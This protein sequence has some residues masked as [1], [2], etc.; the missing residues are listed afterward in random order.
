MEGDVYKRVADCS[1]RLDDE[2][3][4]IVRNCSICIEGEPTEE[5]EVSGYRTC[6]IE[7]IVRGGIALV[8][9][10]GIALKGLSSEDVLASRAGSGSIPGQ[11]QKE[12]GDL[13]PSSCRPHCRTAVFPLP[14]GRLRL[15][16]GRP[17]IQAWL[18]ESNP[19][20]LLWASL[21]QPEPRSQSSRAR[22]QPARQLHRGADGAAAERGC[23]RLDS[24]DIWNGCR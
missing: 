22:R 2:I 18:Q 5:E 21:W 12:G 16:Y 1:I 15:R 19:S 13:H 10:E 11:R 9:A 4:T 8:S 6:Q 20:M 24:I 17:E 3:R 7:P 23:V 14:A